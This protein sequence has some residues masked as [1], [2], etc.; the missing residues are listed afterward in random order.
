MRIAIAS[1]AQE[2]NSFSPVPTT[3]DTFRLYGLFEGP[4]MLDECRGIGAVGGFLEMMDATGAW[5]PLPI[6]HGWVGASGLLT[7]DT[8]DWFAER[9]RSGLEQSSPCD[10]LYFALHGAGVAAQ[11]YDSEGYLLKIARDVIGDEIPVIISLDHHANLTTAMVN[12]VD[13][14]VAHRTQPHDQVDT[15]RQAARLLLRIVRDGDRPMRAWRKVPL[16]THQQQF[17]TSGGPMKQW[18]DLAREMERRPG[19]MSTST[20]PMQPWLDVPEGGWAAAV[21]TDSDQALAESLADELATCAWGLRDE[22]SRMVSIAAD[23]AV[24]RAQRM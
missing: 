11:A 23:T 6:F 15:G 13:A 21:I 12:R 4:E 20:L 10:A 9:L 19:V 7:D 8:L 5:T 1:Y 14:L 17:L 18:F 16:I 24:K 2:T 3:L 22:F